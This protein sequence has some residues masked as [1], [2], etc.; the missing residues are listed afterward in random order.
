M[1]NRRADK[2]ELLRIAEAVA[3]EK[4][5]DKELIIDSMENGIAK[6]AKSKFGTENEIIVKINRESG[7]IE[8]YRK[9]IIV[10][11]VTNSNIEIDLKKAH[12]L[13]DEFEEK[14]IG[15]EILQPLPSFDFGRIAAQTAKQVITYSVREAERERQY[16]DFKEKKDTIL[17]GIVKRLEFGN[18]IVDLGGTEA[19]IQKNEM[20]PRE[21]I[22]AGDRVKAYCLDVR[23]EPRGQQIFLSRAH[24]KFMEKLF[25]QE[26]PEIYDGL[27]EIKSSARD[28][29]SRAKICVKAID[30]SLD[31]VGAC[32]GMRGSRVQ[33]VVNELQGEKIDIVNWSED[34]AIVVSNALSPAEVQRVNVDNQMKKLDVILNEENLSKAIGRRGQNVRLATKLLNYEINI[35]TD[36]EDSE[37]RQIEF[38]E[39]TEN[40]I[41]S[42]ELDETLGQLL[43]AEGFSTIDEIKDSST[44]DLAKIEGIEEDTAKELIDRAKEFY[45]KDQEEIS[46]KV[47]ELGLDKELINLK[48]LT[49]GMLVTLGEKKIL[50]L[51][52]FADLASDEL[53]GGFDVVKGEKVKIKG[54]LEDFA[55]SKQEADELIMSARSIAYKD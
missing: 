16:N 37:R 33:A 45:L 7:E 2:S 35:M 36:Q 10:D 29:G 50:T 26:V 30:T 46:K 24:P 23:R 1:L 5:I 15:D 51:N 4:S 19:I 12:S 11:K 43:V 39:K 8:I 13:G 40:L 54:Y 25:I 38:K 48:G 34:P 6:A 49:P 32:V 9:L 31:P 53:T 18:V 27:I 44:D 14:N 21:N 41:K 52:D 28:P 42:L 17:S 3:I 20:I 22:K 47:Q 55:L